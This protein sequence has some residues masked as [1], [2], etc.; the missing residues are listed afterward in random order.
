MFRK[1]NRNES[2]QTALEAAIILI[3]FIVVASVFA[4][5]VLS[6]GSKSTEKGTQAISAGLQGV[7]S[8]LETKGAIIAKSDTADQVDFIVMTLSLV[9]GG[10]PVDMGTTS[11]KVVI[12]Y[13]DADQ[14]VN[15][16]PWTIE[17]GGWL[18]TIDG[19]TSADADDLLEPGELV[20][21]TVP[22]ASLT[23]TL[24]KNTEFTLEIK[25]PV[26]AVINMTR[27]TPPAIETVM[28]LQ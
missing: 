8:S 27:T 11:R 14:I 28:E 22:L 4:F 7:Q 21:V 20:E 2:G 10:E 9:A 17:T 6:S 19:D 12:G 25:P 23:T 24:G 18:V 15:S 3:A 13:R 16:L 5:A 1:F 26:G